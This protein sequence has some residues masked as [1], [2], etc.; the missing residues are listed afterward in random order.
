MNPNNPFIPALG[1]FTKYAHVTALAHLKLVRFSKN[2]EPDHYTPEAH[3]GLMDALRTFHAS[4]AAALA[5]F[6]E[7]LE[8]ATEEDSDPS[9]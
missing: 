4:A 6:G 1:A 9:A 7:S 5:E 3:E 2:I 8:P